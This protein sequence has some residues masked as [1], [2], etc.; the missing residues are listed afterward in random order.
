MRALPVA[1]EIDRRSAPHGQ[2]SNAE[3][4]IAVADAA[5][6]FTPSGFLSETG[7][8]STGEAVG[9]VPGMGTGLEVK[10]LCGASW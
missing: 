2:A 10:V 8:G 3:D 7:Q 1:A 5:A 9:S 6:V 4:L